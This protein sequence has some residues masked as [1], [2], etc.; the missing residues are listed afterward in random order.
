MN[1]VSKLTL[2]ADEQLL[3][4]NSQWI[5]MK[6][7]ILDKAT[8]MM[9]N[10]IVKMK[11]AI[12]GAKDY[13]TEEA[14]H[15]EPKIYKGENY[16]MLPYVLLDYPRVFD[17]KN[18]LALRTLCWWGN[19]FSITLHLSGSYKLRYEKVLTGKAD[20]LQ[21]GDYYICKNEDQWQH[22]FEPLNYCLAKDKTRR[23]LKNIILQKDFIKIARKFQLQDWNEMPAILEK[24]FPEFL[25]LIK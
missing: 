21:R 19:F 17:K 8:I 25:E 7:S 1:D 4:S 14:R 18:I 2:S 22:H 13:L 12:A 16:R 10:L 5:F 6:R 11:P 9:S 24:T 3:V 23:E 15:S 20:I